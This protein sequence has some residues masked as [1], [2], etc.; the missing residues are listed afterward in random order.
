MQEKNDQGQENQEDTGNLEIEPLETAP[1]VTPGTVEQP[2]TDEANLAEVLKAKEQAEAQFAQ[3]KQDYLHAQQKITKQGQETARSRDEI[4]VLKAEITALRTL[5]AQTQDEYGE[6]GEEP[7]AQS[8][9]V[10]EQLA[11]RLY[12]MELWANQVSQANQQKEQQRYKEDQVRNISK[13]TGLNPKDAKDYFDAL[14]MGQPA[15]AATILSLAQQEMTLKKRLQL[16]KRRGKGAAT[17]ISSPAGSPSAEPETKVQKI[18]KGMPSGEDRIRFMAEQFGKDPT[19]L[20]DV[21]GGTE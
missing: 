16:E 4:N 2:Q 20:D 11:N 12:Q 19:F 15:Q 5:Q 3:Q 14:Q 10:T 6:F 17:Q 18:L 7:S 1:A 8:N 21:I 9:A 13:K